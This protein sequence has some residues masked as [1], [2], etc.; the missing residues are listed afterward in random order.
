MR[1]IELEDLHKAIDYHKEDQ[2]QKRKEGKG[3][4]E[5]ELASQSEQAVCTSSACGRAGYGAVG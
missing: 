2:L 5:G 4:W 3:H 1:N